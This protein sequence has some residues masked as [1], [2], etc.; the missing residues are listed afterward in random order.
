ME[1]IHLTTVDSAFDFKVAIVEV[2]EKRHRDEVKG[3]P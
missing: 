2:K 3:Q 1:I